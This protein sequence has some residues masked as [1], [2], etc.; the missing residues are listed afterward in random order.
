MYKLENNVSWTDELKNAFKHGITR[1]KIIYD[2]QE[3]NYDNGLKDIELQESRYVPNLGFIGQA[4]SRMATINLLNN[5]QN[6]NLENKELEIYIGADYN[7]QTYYINYGKFIVDSAPENDD[8][9]NTIKVVAYDYMIKFNKPYIDTMTYPCTLKQLLQNLCN[10]AEVELGTLEFANQNFSVVDNQFEGKTLREVLQNIA[11]CAFSWARIGQDNKLYLDFKNEDIEAEI[12]TENDLFIVTEDNQDMVTAEYTE[13][14]MEFLNSDDYLQDN[15]KKA[16]EYY[17]PVNKVTFGDTNIQGQEESVPENVQTEDVHE[18]VIN[19]NLF[20]YTTEKRHE[21]IQAGTKLLGLRYMPIQQLKTIGLIY[22]DCND[23]IKI[24][25]NEGNYVITR[26]FSHIIRYNGVTSDE[27]QTEAPSINE[28]K[29]ENK[30]SSSIQNTRTEVIVDRANKK[31]TS[32]AQQIGDRS[33]KT[34]TI[35]QDIDGI[36]SAVQDIEDLTNTVNGIKTVQINDA[37]PDNDIVELHIYGNNSVFNYLYP[38]DT[39]YPRDNLYPYGDSR[40]RF[41][42]SKEDTTIDLGI[43][44]V[45]R[46]NEEVRDEVFIDNLGNVSLIRRVNKNGTTK[47][48]P[49]IT[50]LGTLHFT[51]RSGNNTFEIVN[52]VAP[53]EIK[54]ALKSNFT[55]IFATKVEMNSEIKQTAQEINLEV[56]KKVGNNEIISKINQTAEQ[57]S[58]EASKININGV[59]SANGNFKIDMYGN[60]TCNNGIFQGDVL[61]NNDNSITIKDDNNI[62]YM[63]LDWGGLAFFQNTIQTNCIVRTTY[64]DNIHYGMSLK[65]TNKNSYVGIS[66]NN[67]TK[68]EYRADTDE[69]ILYK[70]PKINGTASGTMFGEAGGGISVNNGLITRWN[71]SGATGTLSLKDSAGNATVTITVKEGII[72]GWEVS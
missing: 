60:M 22:L 13:E 41:Y 42:N 32:I 64:K 27:F 46:S 61:V 30:N 16:N 69:I 34:T 56:S 54:Y 5:G 70:L 26:C 57:I 66:Y 33:E 12:I 6:V 38:T 65:A 28:K 53:I 55:D 37:Y 15:Y 10:Q 40:L 43:D 23:I 20:A 39:L 25:D 47:V 49:V 52:Y 8:T 58:I 4:A 36:E 1:A 44:E 7:N 11:K 63:S 3:I 72:T 50:H 17:G 21:L 24:E 45:L 71:L 35:T 51:L 67:D 9:N 68:L 59:I 48:N 29:Y 14:M 18:L 31:I 62:K 19:D 2:D